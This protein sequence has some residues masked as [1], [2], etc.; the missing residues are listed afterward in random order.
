M[1]I[2]LYLDEEKEWLGDWP[3]ES[4]DRCGFEQY[5]SLA[6]EM[7]ETVRVRSMEE[8]ISPD[9]YHKRITKAQEVFDSLRA[10]LNDEEDMSE[11]QKEEFKK[12]TF[13]V[14]KEGLRNKEQDVWP[15]SRYFLVNKVREYFNAPYMQT[16]T[17]DYWLTD[18]LI[19]AGISSYR[20]SLLTKVQVPLKSKMIYGSTLDLFCQ[21]V[22]FLIKWALIFL[23][24][25]FSYG[26]SKEI[27]LL[28]GISVIAYQSVKGTISDPW[29]EGWGLYASMVKVYE[30]TEYQNFNASVIWE[31]CAVVREK[32]AVFDG[33]MYDLLQRQMAKH[34]K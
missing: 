7:L 16:N 26:K 6:K 9:D 2:Q 19:Y 8:G 30:H 3:K 31:M 29:E 18:A 15:I 27:F 34:N 23:V 28:L 5:Y 25:F 10:L 4:E 20:K 17:I 11:E 21:T 1:D 24:L 32:G 22:L 13:W 14:H 33:V 12:Q